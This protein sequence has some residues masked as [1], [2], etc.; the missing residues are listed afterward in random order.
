MF[1]AFVHVT[2][3]N[4]VL[5]DLTIKNCREVYYVALPLHHP[6]IQAFADVDGR[7]DAL[8]EIGGR[9]AVFYFE[10]FTTNSYIEL[11]YITR[12]KKVKEKA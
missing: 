5:F 8:L 4:L 11:A 6:A 9:K 1:I 7:I 10:H 3:D 2:N 12:I